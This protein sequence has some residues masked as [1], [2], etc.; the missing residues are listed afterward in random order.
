MNSYINYDWYRN[1][2]MG[3]FQ[4]MNLYP[5][6]EGYEKGNLFNDL[7]SQYKNY[8]PASLKPINEQEKK[9]YELSAIA[10]A[11]HE[12][13]LY[14]DLHP[15]DQSMLALFNDYRRKSNDLIKEY[16]EKFGPLSVSSNSMEGKN[17]FT[18]EKEAWPWEG[19]NV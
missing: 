4:N 14:L 2:S 13:N 16:E 8:R 10:F 1:T 15:S 5:P 11:A 3:G 18:W 6:K 12:L 19:R 7:Y 9:L 17:T